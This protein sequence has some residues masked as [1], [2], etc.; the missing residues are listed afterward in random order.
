MNKRQRKKLDKKLNKAIRD[1]N[2]AVAE[3]LGI[4]V[5]DEGLLD[6]FNNVKSHPDNINKCFKAY[7]KLL[8]L[9]S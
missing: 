7:K 6:A 1:L 3:D 8:M 2:N 4:T 9:N 5:S